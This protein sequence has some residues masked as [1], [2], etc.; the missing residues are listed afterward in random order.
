MCGSLVKLLAAGG[1]ITEA[2]KLSIVVLSTPSAAPVVLSKE[3]RRPLMATMNCVGPTAPIV[4]GGYAPVSAR[5]APVKLMAVVCGP[6]GWAA[7][8]CRAR[9][10]GHWA[11]F[12]A[13]E[14]CARWVRSGRRT[15]H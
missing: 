1:V 3:R 15:G 10:A 13:A 6:S 12:T 8:G 14:F 11:A 2:K 5:V 7:I 9:P 4:S